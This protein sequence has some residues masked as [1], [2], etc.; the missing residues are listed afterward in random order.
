M[1]AEA[2]VFVVEDDAS[3]R[4]A[5]GRLLK[6]AGFRAELF[7]T[8][9]EFLAGPAPEMPGCAVLDVHLPGLGGLDVQR[10]LHENRLGL[11][12]VFIT[13][14]GDVPTTVRAMKGGAVDFLLKPFRPED[15][16]AAVREGLA[17]QAQARQTQAGLEELRHRAEALTPREREVMVCVVSGL[18]NKQVGRRL[19]VGEK[20]IKVHRGRVMRKMGAAS[21]A[22]LVRMVEKLE[23][24]P[25]PEPSNGVPDVG[26]RSSHV[27][28]TSESGGNHGPETCRGVR[29][30]A[31]G[32]R[33]AR[34]RRRPE[35]A[36]P[37]RR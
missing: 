32:A 16:L 17:R 33:P 1:S 14:Y 7:G 12:V 36:R 23:G 4:K 2:S 26:P 18:P 29:G 19:G 8:A 15:L 5:L 3:V 13:G 37:Q 27:V 6:A 24:G 30:P 11:P 10:I 34:P 20:T 22:E 25:P 31:G 9:E 21:F 35:K 28:I